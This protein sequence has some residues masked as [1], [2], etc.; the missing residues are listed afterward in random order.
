MI[1]VSTVRA[2]VKEHYSPNKTVLLHYNRIESK[3]V[4]VLLIDYWVK[5]PEK[6]L[7]MIRC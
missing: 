2:A 7:A 1:L 6:L 5:I 4:R 3:T